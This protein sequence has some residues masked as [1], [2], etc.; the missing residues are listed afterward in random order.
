MGKHPFSKDELKKVIGEPQFRKGAKLEVSLD[1]ID[2]IAKTANDNSLGD[3]YEN[4]C[5]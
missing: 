3:S 2:K 4:N 5:Q 1:R